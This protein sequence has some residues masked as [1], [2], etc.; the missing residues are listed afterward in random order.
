[1][2]WEQ[3]QIQVT[4]A[5]TYISTM[6]LI[7][8]QFCDVYIELSDELIFIFHL[9]LQRNHAGLNKQEWPV[10]NATEKLLHAWLTFALLYCLSVS[11]WV[12]TSVWLLSR[13]VAVSLRAA[14]RSCKRIYRHTRVSSCESWLFRAAGVA[15]R[16]CTLHFNGELFHFDLQLK[17]SFFCWL[18]FSLSFFVK[19]G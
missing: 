3:E 16:V 15:Y 4:L 12:A 6:N 10:V 14:T 8:L 11:C 5:R 18:G 2:V 1:M 7:W 19:A 13:S 9:L 17:H